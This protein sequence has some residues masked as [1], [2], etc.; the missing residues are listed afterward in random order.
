MSR[1]VCYDSLTSPR[2]ANVPLICS[3]EP[4]PTLQ[5]LYWG[6]L[7][8][9]SLPALSSG[10]W[11]LCF[12]WLGQSLL[13]WPGHAM[14]Q[15]D[16]VWTTVVGGLASKWTRVPNQRT[17][18]GFSWTTPSVVSAAGFSSVVPPLS[19]HPH[20]VGWPILGLAYLLFTHTMG[21]LGS[22]AHAF[23]CLG[24][25]NLR[26][27]GRNWLNKSSLQNRFFSPAFCPLP[28]GG[29]TSCQKSP[30]RSREI[31]GC[32]ACMVSIV[33]PTSDMIGSLIG[34][35]RQSGQWQRSV[36]HSVV[37]LGLSGVQGSARPSE[38]WG[39]FWRRPLA[40]SGISAMS[41]LTH[42]HPFIP[43]YAQERTAHLLWWETYRTTWSLGKQRCNFPQLVVSHTPCAADVVTHNRWKTCATLIGTIM[44]RR[45]VT[46][47][48]SF[49]YTVPQRKKSV[50]QTSANSAV[51]M[52]SGRAA[53]WGLKLTPSGSQQCGRT[54][55]MAG[56]K[57]WDQAKWKQKEHRKTED[58]PSHQDAIW[59]TAPAS[60]PSWSQANQASWTAATGAAWHR[61]SAAAS[62]SS[63]S[64]DCCYLKKAP[65]ESKPKTTEDPW[66]KVDPWQTSMTWSAQ[67]QAPWGAVVSDGQLDTQQSWTAPPQ[68]DRQVDTQQSQVPW[69]PGT[70]RRT[71][72]GVLLSPVFTAFGA[73]A[74]LNTT[75]AQDHKAAVEGRTALQKVRPQAGKNGQNTKVHR[76]GHEQPADIGTG[77]GRRS[78]RRWM[79]LLVPPRSRC[80]RRTK[81]R[82]GKSSTNGWR[83]EVWVTCGR[84]EISR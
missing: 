26:K 11:P 17:R 56:W 3:L 44:D 52:L 71:K 14:A 13:L 48:S 12:F 32:C 10:T 37:S 15:Q 77:P 5:L 76:R 21:L 50:W 39:I 43:S 34:A 60:Q 29:Q 8:F 78:S 46:H 63:S 42:V 19:G 6:A 31:G 9:L 4:R 22:T 74:N 20:D 79:G 80:R 24:Q 58:T 66:T 57:N 64:G 75:A 25:R 72:Y 62:S 81:T 53:C 67:G 82:P 7:S 47:H 84:S 73:A 41:A 18:S 1:L 65:T 33:W 49:V 59:K 36:L 27:R 30:G 23:S 69:T 51:I 70:E 2:S 40:M 55:G 38:H 54:T 45:A 28:D 61:T 68:N 35:Q 83:T 16:A